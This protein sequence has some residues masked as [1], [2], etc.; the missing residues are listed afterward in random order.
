MTFACHAACQRIG[1]QL[2]RVS[3]DD[4]AERSFPPVSPTIDCDAQHNATQYG[5]HEVDIAVQRIWYSFEERPQLHGKQ[6]LVQSAWEREIHESCFMEWVVKNFD[7]SR[8]CVK[9]TTRRQLNEAD[10]HSCQSLI[11][12]NLPSLDFQ[13]A[14]WALRFR[15]PSTPKGN[16]LLH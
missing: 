4:K 10:K 5:R 6:L 8:L 13:Y 3:A 12:V 11:Y 1:S 14:H 2:Q 9:G 15:S 7:L 16:V